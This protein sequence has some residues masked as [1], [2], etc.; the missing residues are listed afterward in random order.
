MNEATV[1]LLGFLALLGAFIAGFFFALERADLAIVPFLGSGLALG[2][3]TAAAVR[4]PA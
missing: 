4:R 3:I 2:R 1:V